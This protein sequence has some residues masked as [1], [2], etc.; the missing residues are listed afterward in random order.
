M[1]NDSP[2]PPEHNTPLPLKR[3]P[4]A[5]FKRVLGSAYQELR[6]RRL[7]PPSPQSLLRAHQARLPV[8]AN[9]DHQQLRRRHPVVLAIVPGVDDLEER[10]ASFVAASCAALHLDVDRSLEHIDERREWMHVATCFTPRADLHPQC[11]HFRTIRL[12][13]CDRDSRDCSATL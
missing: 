12:W 2:C 3:S 5:S 8:H 7:D 10:I 13:V 4:P 11:G 6:G 9:K 1:V